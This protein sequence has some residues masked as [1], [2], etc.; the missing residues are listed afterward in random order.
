MLE[1]SSVRK[2]KI[3]LADY[4]YQQD[5]ESRMLMSDFTATDL[6]VLEEILFSPLKIPIKKLCRTRNCSDTE[7]TPILEKLSK[8][9]LLTIQGDVLLIDK[10]RRKYFEFQIT[11]FADGFSPNMEFLQNL[12][13]QVPIHI[14]PTWYAIPRSSNNI[15]ESIVEKYLITP[16]VYQ[17]YLMELNF[18]DPLLA[19]IMQDVFSAPDF[20]ISTS[21]LIAK[22][23]LARKDFE[24]LM[25]QLEFNFICFVTYCREE[26]YWQEFVTPFHEWREYLQF[27][28]QTEAP[29]IHEQVSIFRHRERDFAFVEDM[30]I[31]LN[32]LKK[33]PLHCDHWDPDKP[34]PLSVTAAL[35]SHCHIP[36]DAPEELLF[37]QRYLARIA[38]KLLLLK[39]AERVNN[40]LCCSDAANDWI[41]LTPENRALN[42]YRNPL[43]RFSS[44]RLPS[45]LCS[46]RSMRE[47]EKS[48]KRVLHGGWVL[49]DDFIRGAIV[50]FSEDNAVLL[51]KFGKHWKYALPQYN[52][53][54]KTLIKAM[55]FDFLFECGFV[56]TGILDH[57]D[58]FAVT[59]FGQFFFEE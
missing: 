20:R 47:A 35:A 10:E 54:E 36:A 19:A 25:L 53:E 28:R 55:I 12:L 31:V 24:Q 14:L 39:L 59:A 13:K 3:N 8:A 57:R 7:L 48:I 27:L 29:M 46:E 32:L 52:E 26:D 41:G 6:D 49:F 1:L 30:E 21:D 56:A 2:N 16:Q 5:I 11:R 33:K 58:C 44:D 17:R 37:A 22:Y 40:R 9:G 15:F 51:K 34:L 43:N 38:D 45:A 4:P 42:L 18:P 23:N 50:S